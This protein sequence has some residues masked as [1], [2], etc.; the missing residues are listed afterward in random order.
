MVYCHCGKQ[1]EKKTDFLEIFPLHCYL[2]FPEHQNSL[3]V[4]PEYLSS[5]HLTLMK[6]LLK[7]Q[8]LGLLE[9]IFSLKLSLFTFKARTNYLNC[10]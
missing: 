8:S 6:K 9:H 1:K 10:I 4:Q 7:W 5:Y 3:S 2:T